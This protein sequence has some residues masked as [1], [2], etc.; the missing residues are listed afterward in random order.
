[1]RNVLARAHL[2]RLYLFS[3]APDKALDT[4][5][6]VIDTHPDDAQLLTVRAAARIQKKDASG[7]LQDAERAVQL[8]PTYEDAVAVLAGIYSSNGNKPKAQAL[9]EQSIQNIPET[10]D[11]RLVLAQIYVQSGHPD[12]AEAV[13]IK[14][15]ALKPDERAHRLRL[16]Q[17][18]AQT[19]QVDAAET[20]LRRRSKTYR[21][22]ATSS[23]R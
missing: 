12:Q 3:A 18:Y 21:A 2:A 14:L 13:L 6:P 16:A 11:L 19:N 7:A 22:S 4:L 8:A 20:V 5:A 1:M 23:W 17:F 10:V 9:L 15:V